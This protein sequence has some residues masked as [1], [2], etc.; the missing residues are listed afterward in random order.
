MTGHPTM[1]HTLYLFGIVLVVALLLEMINFIEGLAGIEHADSPW[2]VWPH[3]VI[4]IPIWLLVLA[5]HLLFI[6]IGLPLIAWQSGYPTVDEN[7]RLQFRA[8][9][10]WLYG[11]REDGIDGRG[12]GDP[13][14]AWWME[15]TKGVTLRERIFE[16]S[17]LRNPVNNLRYIP[18]ICPKFR[19]KWIRAVGTG[20]EPPDGQFGWAFVWQGPYSGLY[21][22]TPRIWFWIGWKFKP[23]DMKGIPETDTRLPRCDFAAQ[24]HILGKKT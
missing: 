1:M 19:P 13:E 5:I 18:V 22:K 2:T 12:G 6:L 3:I 4:S 10:M 17:A 14:Q 7:K 8:R 15:R 21:I 23:S 16:W 24:F 11:N 20:D 9:W